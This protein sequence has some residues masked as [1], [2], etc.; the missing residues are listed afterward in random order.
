[1]GGKGYP[2]VFTYALQSWGSSTYKMLFIYTT[3]CACMHAGSF[4]SS[5]YSLQT[6][7]SKGSRRGPII[8][9]EAHLSDPISSKV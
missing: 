2:A 6:A 9:H 8:I 3:R 1:M 4:H 5:V 7:V